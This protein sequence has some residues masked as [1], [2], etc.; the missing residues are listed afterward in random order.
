MAILVECPVCRNVQSKKTKPVS[1]AQ[2]EE[3]Q[4][5]KEKVKY[6]IVYR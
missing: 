2:P 6:Y 1:V 5:Q 4:K 3:T